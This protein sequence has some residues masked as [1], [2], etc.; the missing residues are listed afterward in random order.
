[1]YLR[2]GL[3]SVSFLLALAFSAGQSLASIQNTGFSAKKDLASIDN[4]P[5]N[6]ESLTKQ[7]SGATVLVG[8]CD[9]T[10]A[11][12]G[13]PCSKF[14]TSGSGFFVNAD[15]LMLTARH[16]VPLP[17]PPNKAVF[18]VQKKSDGSGWW[19]VS[20]NIFSEFPELDTL[21]IKFDLQGRKTQWLPLSLTPALQGEEIGVFGYPADDF[22]LRPNGQFNGDRITSRVAKTI[23]SS[24]ERRS[25]LFKPNVLLNNKEMIE[26]QFVFVK[27]NSGGPVVSV[28]TG[29]VIGIV[30]GQSNVA[31]DFQLIPINA[32]SSVGAIPFATYSYAIS[33]HELMSKLS[34]TLYSSNWTK[35]VQSTLVSE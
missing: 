5:E 14:Q 28:R 26:A 29:K 17:L 6:F 20:R 35:A 2:A 27:G 7:L 8:L 24:V 12:G 32:Q 25:I 13:L 31:Q 10:Q 23:A 22:E 33:I 9:T 1:M 11:A 16:V 21:A 34:P 15:G 19:A 18:I 30:T 3:L 4:L